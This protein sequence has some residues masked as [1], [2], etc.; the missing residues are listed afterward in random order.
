MRAKK[1]ILKSVHTSFNNGIRA[2]KSKEAKAWLESKG[3][4][5]DLTG[6]C[7]SSGQLHH[8]R[9]QDFINE[10]L[11]VGFLV[12][13]NAAVRS[14]EMKAYTSFGKEA[15]VF[16]LKNEQNETVNFFGIR[17]NVADEP[18]EYLNED[19]I[20]PSY[21][22]ELTERLF[23]T[24]NI[25]DAATLLETRILDNRDAVISMNEGLFIDEQ[26]KA[27]KGLTKLKEVI[28][29][30][31]KNDKND[32]HSKFFKAATNTELTFVKLPEDHSLN[33]MW[34][35]YGLHGLNELLK[36]K[37]SVSEV[38]EAHLN[39]LI[40]TSKVE[41]PAENEIVLKQINEGKLCYETSLGT[42]YI[43]GNISTDLGT[44]KATFCFEEAAS[45][46]KHRN[47][48][49]LYERQQ[50]LAFAK[51]V[52]EAEHLDINQVE[53]ELLKLTDLLDQHREKQLEVEH[54][55]KNKT[56]NLLP[57]EKEREAID[58]LNQPN[59]ID[60]IDKLIATS[61][62]VGEENNRKMVFIIASTYK[63]PN[64][65][66]G[67]VQGTSGSGKTHLITGIAGLMPP[68]DVLNMTR[69]TSKSF[70]NYR[71]DDLVN[72]LILIQDIDGL[73]DEAMFAFRE[74]QSAGSVSS[75]TAYK[76]KFGQI[77][78]TVKTVNAHFAS[79]VAT[80][81]AE[82]YFDN[83]SRSIVLGIDE[84][85]EQTQHIIQQQNKKRAGFID[86][87]TTLQAKELLQNCIRTLKPYE[88]VNRFADKLNLPVEAKMLRRL[89]NHYQD[90][91]IQ[92]TL[93]N[94]YQRNKDEQGRLITT[95]E[96]LEQAC[97]IMFDA[98]MW[99]IDELDSSLR[100]FFERLK[101]YIKKQNNTGQYKF[102]TREIRQAFNISKSQASRYIQDLKNLEYIQVADGS[103]N[104]G[105]TYKIV[106]WDDMEKIRQK[107]KAELMSQIAELK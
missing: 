47:K 105:F 91:V 22:H 38:K 93:L 43:L 59:V 17:I 9:E 16:A 100:Q 55:Q 68:E 33:D 84:S 101:T 56:V 99:K 2:A 18:S 76:N 75:S 11:S 40:S 58:F 74:L 8:R 70:Y 86:E 28:F 62:I 69:V 72:K 92:T 61:G 94:Q 50:I 32:V 3:L 80:T 25:L 44:L 23:V 5:I 88:V 15:I 57:P 12:P 41:V 89:N 98:I 102:C 30:G 48:F 66:H 49:D 36:G 6:A 97:T 78:S 63:M 87:K 77:V 37:I 21:P 53:A 54:G 64:T 13:S 29:I 81:H 14:P 65:L 42:Y 19:G 73:D 24:D 85:E 20:Y 39:T 106:F 79:L 82:I 1:D 107:V 45:K 90:F 52:S 35:T 7:F 104:K 10:L 95:V 34:V 51:T 46:R 71:N 60:N 103:A 27:A 31:V 4:S 67:L 96:D 26:M 83:L